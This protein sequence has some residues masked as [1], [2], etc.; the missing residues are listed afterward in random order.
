MPHPVD[1]DAIGGGIRHQLFGQQS[2][3]TTG[4][5]HD[6]DAVVSDDGKFVTNRQQVPR[7]VGESRHHGGLT[8]AR[9]TRSVQATMPARATIARVC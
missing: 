8:L 7:L 4:L 1:I 5:A 6:V 3:S 2:W 9:D